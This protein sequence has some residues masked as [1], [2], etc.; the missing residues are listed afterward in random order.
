MSGGFEPAGGAPVRNFEPAGG[1][2]VR[3]FEPAGGA[4]AERD[5]RKPEVFETWVRQLL[6]GLRDDLSPDRTDRLFSGDHPGFSRSPLAL[7]NGAAGVLWSLGCAS[8]V[9]AP[10]APE[11]ATATVD[12]IVRNGAAAAERI[13]GGLYDSELGA[14]YALW[15]AGRP[16]H[17][18]WLVDLSLVKDR[19]GCDSGQLVTRARRLVREIGKGAPA[20]AGLFTGAPGLALALHRYGLLVVDREA[21]ELARALLTAEFASYIRRED[22]SLQ[23]DNG[24]RKTLAYLAVGSCGSALV[25]S[26]LSAGDGWC[27][28]GVELADLVRAMGAETVV[29]SGLF[30]GRSGFLAGLAALSLAGNGGPVD[31][32]VGRHLRHLELHEVNPRPGVLRFAGSRNLR[33][34]SDLATGAAGVLSAVSFATGRSAHWLP[35]LF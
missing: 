26:E 19:G 23:Y 29:Q 2:P 27:P 3:N 18:R 1:A 24:A 13:E 32:F 11:L 12:W 4:A 7:A 16:D 35:G 34:A 10:E 8:D 21:V 17:A 6:R 15:C 30:R 9:A 5:L 25:L 28:D 14:G 33:L 22:G 31:A 20:P